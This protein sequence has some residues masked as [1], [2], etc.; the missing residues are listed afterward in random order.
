MVTMANGE[1]LNRD[2][3]DQ[4]KLEK[5]MRERNMFRNIIDN[6]PHAVYFK[7][8][9]SRFIWVSKIYGTTQ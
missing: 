9:E 1:K 5:L 7:D 8:K 2:V 4:T 6:I 3:I